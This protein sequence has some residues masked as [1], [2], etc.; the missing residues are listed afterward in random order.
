[1][2]EG[3]DERSSTEPIIERVEMTP[4]RRVAKC[5]S[6]EQPLQYDAGL[7]REVAEADLAVAGAGHVC[8]TAGC[9]N[10]TSLI[11]WLHRPHPY[12][13]YLPEE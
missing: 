4:Y 3:R 7:F 9:D 6:C 12:I 2:N 8:L 13:E 5:P 11:V 1:M 10:S